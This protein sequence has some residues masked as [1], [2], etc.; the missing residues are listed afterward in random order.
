MPA[1]SHS[2]IRRRQPRSVAQISSAWLAKVV[3]FIKGA[4]AR[5]IP[6]PQ[7]MVQVALLDSSTGSFTLSFANLVFMQRYK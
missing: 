7:A 2:H 4:P 6:Y 5:T 1:E 3:R